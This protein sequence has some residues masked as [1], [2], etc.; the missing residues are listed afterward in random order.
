[1]LLA[2]PIKFLYCGFTVA[3][4]NKGDYSKSVG[5]TQVYLCFCE[6]FQILGELYGIKGGI[7]MLIVGDL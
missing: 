1:V 3:A 6:A 2:A 5:P 4:N 7:G